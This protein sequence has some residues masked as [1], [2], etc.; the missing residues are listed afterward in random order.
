MA[1]SKPPRG[2]GQVTLKDVAHEAGVSYQ[3]VSRA[4]NGLPEVSPKTSAKI[5]EIAARLGY[6]PNRVAGSLRTSRSKV[7]GLIL[8]DVE[9]TFFAEVASAVEAEAAARGY[10]VIL[11]NSGESIERER[12]AAISLVERRVDGLIITPAEGSH[13]YLRELLPKRFPVVAVNRTIDDM[14]CS[15]V[16]TENEQGARTAV[17]YLIDRG[18]TRIGAVVGS[19]GLITSRERLAGFVA[20]LRSA[21]LPLRQDWV[22]VGGL[23]PDIARGA[24]TRIMSQPDRPTA[25]FASNNKISE[26]ILLALSELGLKRGRDVD[27]VGFDKAPWIRLV[28]PPLPVVAQQTDRIG[29]EAVK[30]LLSIM[31][32]EVT[33]P[34]IVRVPVRVSAGAESNLGFFGSVFGDSARSRS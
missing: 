15:A 1:R 9:N 24:T 26:G 5:R 14:A 30:L 10:S 4:V 2:A 7:I 28:D 33:S 20:E 13:A 23:F 22:G 12:I 27:V 31:A 8:S 17:R 25:L 19:P 32:E 34:Q 21:G 6:R 29:V 11:A 18:H 16:L 3:T